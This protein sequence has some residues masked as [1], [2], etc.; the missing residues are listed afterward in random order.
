MFCTLL[1][2]AAVVFVIYVAWKFTT[3]DADWQSFHANID[4]TY[5][6]NKVIWVTG[7]SSGIGKAF[8]RKIAS[9]SDCTF[10]LTARHEDTLKEVCKEIESVNSKCKA[11]IFP[12]DLGTTGLSYYESKVD[13]QFPNGVDMIVHN[14]GYSMRSCAV[15]FPL[16]N[17]MDMFQ[18]DLLSPVILTKLLLPYMTTKN[19]QKKHKHIVVISSVAGIALTP[20]RTT[21]GC[22]KAGIAAFH[23]SLR[24]EVL[25]YNVSI[26]NVFP[27][28]VATNIDVNSVGKGGKNSRQ[29]EDFIQKGLSV[30]RCAEIICAS[31]S[32]HLFECW[33]AKHPLLYSL[34]L[35]TYLPFLKSILMPSRAKKLLKTYGY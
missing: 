7:A 19:L 32:N 12:M 2:I 4:P 26:L 28:Y 25:P 15:D 18:V 3:L 13:E 14:A 27:G 30:N 24:Y 5:F 6:D 33:P 34:Y 29:Q 35:I 20:I 16:K 21:Y 11:V 22:C 10:V 9:F 23:E 1:C 8:V 31:I 17:D